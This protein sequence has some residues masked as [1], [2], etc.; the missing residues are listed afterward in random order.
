MGLSDNKGELRMLFRL[1]GP[2]EVPV[3]IF[4]DSQHRDRM[5][6]GLDLYDNDEEPFIATF[7]KSGK[8][9]LLVGKY[10]ERQH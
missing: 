8:K 2:N 7:D 4:K 3:L 10:L 1:F 5:V 9:Q 6:L